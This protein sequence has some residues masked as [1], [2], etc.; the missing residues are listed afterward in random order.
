MGNLLAS[1]ME[2]LNFGTKDRRVLMLGLDGAGKTTI[3][4]KLKFGDTVNTVPTIGF[5][6]ETIQFKNLKFNVW[7]IGGQDKIRVFWKHYFPGTDALI[8]VVDTSDK[9]RVK[10]CKEELHK[11]LTDE[12]L[13]GIPVLIL[14]N[15]M[16][17]NVM[18]SLE[19][20][21]NLDLE[22]L[23]GREWYCQG[24]SA[25]N[26]SGLYEGFN[27]LANKLNTKK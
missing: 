25:L 27:W 17:L 19:V 23:K 9:K 1:L 14:A 7:D 21:N 13:K 22:A 10:L 15:K 4:M 6:V 26:G 20:T 3:T 5:G 12:D 11:I 8:Y 24:C 18:S 2:K 16:D